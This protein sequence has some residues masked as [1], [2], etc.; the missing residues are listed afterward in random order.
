MPGFWTSPWTTA[1]FTVSS[2]LVGTGTAYPA[3]ITTPAS[4]AASTA[5]SS[6][7]TASGPP[8]PRRRHTVSPAKANSPP[9]RATAKLTSGAPPSAASGVNGEWVLAKA[10]R[11]QG[12][13]PNGTRSR[14][15]SSATHRQAPHTGHPRSRE[16]RASPA[17]SAAT[18]SASA[19]DRPTTASYPTTS[20]QRSSS[21]KNG[22]ARTKPVH[23][24]WRPVRPWVIRA[25]AATPRT[26]S[27]HTSYGGKAKASATPVAAARPVRAASRRVSAASR[28]RRPGRGAAGAGTASGRLAA[29]S[30]AVS[31]V[32]S[33]P[34]GTVAPS[35][36]SFKGHVT[37]PRGG[38]GPCPGCGKAAR[39]PR[40]ERPGRGTAGGRGRRVGLGVLRA[41][42]GTAGCG[43]PWNR[44]L[45]NV[46]AP[47]GS[48]L[49]TRRNV[50]RPR[51]L[52]L[53]PSGGAPV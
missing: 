26:D 41:G 29:G 11:P 23:A 39:R 42:R 15:H 48:H 30:P 33:E 24:P 7:F 17:P 3:R 16:V 45:L 20:S 47:P 35:C 2:A 40:G 25:S 31:A 36:S 52:D 43:S 49:P 27:G 53:A 21:T 4:A 12:K 14:A 46:R 28:A 1:M 8:A 10:S 37:V 19:T 38:Y 34:E 9:A 5:G 44:C 13:P 6:A 51:A 18:N 22:R 50:P 32:V